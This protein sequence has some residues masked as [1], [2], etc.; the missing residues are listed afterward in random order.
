[1]VKARQYNNAQSMRVHVMPQSQTEM[2]LTDRLLTSIV[3]K[4]ERQ[5]DV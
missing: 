2:N 1:M 3:D 5:I 4:L